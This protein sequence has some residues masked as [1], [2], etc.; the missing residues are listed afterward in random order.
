MKKSKISYYDAHLDYETP[1]TVGLLNIRIRIYG[2]EKGVDEAYFVGTVGKFVR[3]RIPSDEIVAM[4]PKL[5]TEARIE[6]KLK[7]EVLIIE[8]LS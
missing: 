8:K 4:L 7:T 2:F 3:E 1:L 6:Y 5:L